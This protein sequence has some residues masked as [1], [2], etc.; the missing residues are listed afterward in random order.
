MSKVIQVIKP[1]KSNIGGTSIINAPK[2]KVAAYARVSTDYEDQIN[3]YKV[4]CEEYDNIITSNPN[5][6]F[7]GIFADQ[8]LSGTQAKKRPEFM[9]MIESARAGEIDLIL[10]KSISRFGRNTVDVITYMR[11]LREIGVE[12]FF[13]KENIS[14]LDPKIDFMLT[15]LSSI[16]QEESRSIST[17]V[18]WS[19]EKKFKKGIV[20][21]RRI[22]GYDVVDSKYQIIPEEA[23]VVRKMFELV[24]RGHKV[25]DIA[26]NLNASGIKS[27]TN[28]DWTYGAIKHILSN[29][30]YIGDA[31]LRKT[32]TIDYLTKKVVKN[33]NVADKYYVSN[34]HEAIITKD[35]FEAVQ[36]LLKDKS[37]SL[38]NT[39]KI[40]KYPLSGIIY[41]P[42]CGRTLKRQQVNRGVNMRVVFNCNHYYGNEQLCS[43]TT[44]NYDLVLEATYDSIRELYSNESALENLFEVFDNNIASNNLRKEINRLKDDVDSLLSL[45]YEDTENNDIVNQINFN[46]EQIENLEQEL[47]LSV[48]SSV[49]LDHIKSL[50]KKEQFTDSLVHPKDFY[51][52]IFAD[53]KKIT[54]IISATK[55]IDE[56]LKIY[57]LVLKTEP[58][59]SK[60]YVAKSGKEGIYYE[61]LIYE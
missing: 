14:S 40:T 48:T 8:G 19:Y 46:N 9:R 47:I 20:D 57:K 21:A 22:Y 32:V 27:L 18:K 7:A 50:V 13:E 25:N 11:E 33:D 36:L 43:S 1:I 45:H 53:T 24:L 10:T 52:L 60:M 23:D 30:R 49:R 56:L 51:S 39:S 3:S 16:A 37:R 35:D 59:L 58:L 29:E 38:R 31:L 42:K 28:K 44:P 26:K 41:C 6:V 15:I 61:V 55:T 17:N 34:N 54:F 12:I 5:Y 4:Q 2:K